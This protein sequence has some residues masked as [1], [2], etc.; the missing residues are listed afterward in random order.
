[1]A[2]CMAAAM[3][4]TAVRILVCDCSCSWLAAD[5]PALDHLEFERFLSFD[6]A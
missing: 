4:V 1:M 6:H 2:S 5:V 3:S